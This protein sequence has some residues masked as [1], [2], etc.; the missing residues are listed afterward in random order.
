MKKLISLCSLVIAAIPLLFGQAFSLDQV[1]S[2][3]FTYGMDAAR[4]QDRFVWAMNESGVRNLFVAEG[5]DFTPRQLT[6]Y[7]G[8]EGQEF[9]SIQ[10][11]DNGEWIMYIRGGDFGSNWD[12]EKPVNPN[13]LT[14]VPSVEIWSIPFDGGDPISHG[15]GLQ[16]Q[17]APDGS[18]IAFTKSDQIW[19]TPTNG[20]TKPQKLFQARGSNGGISWGPDSRA[21]AFTSYRGDHSFIG[22]YRDSLQPIE[23]VTPSFHRDANVV[24]SPDGDQLAFIRRPGVGGA[25]DSILGARHYPWKI[26]AYDVVKKSAKSIWKAPKTIAGSPPTTQGRYNLRWGKDAITFLSYHDKWPHLYAISAKGGEAQLLTDGNYMAEY[27]S[28]SPDGRSLLFA[29]NTGPDELDIDRRHVVQVSVDG[30]QENV[31]TPGA[32]NEWTPYLLSSGKYIACISAG[33]Q[34]PPLPT[35]ID[36]ETKEMTLLGEDRIPTNFPA[37]DLVIPTQVVFKAPDGQS[38]HG[39]LFKKEGATTPAPAVVYIHGGPPRQMLLGWHYSSYYSNA[40]ALNQY[41]ANQGFVVLSVNYRLGIGYGYDFHR[42][43]DG[44]TRGASEYQ[45]IKAAGEWLA[46]QPEV[47][48]SRVSVYGGSYGGYL[49]AMALGRDS[50]LFAAGVDIHGVHDRINGRV[51]RYK[52]ADAYELAPDVEEAIKIAWQSSPVAD[53]AGWTSP[54]LIIHGDDDRN[55]AFSQSVDLVQRLE[56]KGVEYE[57]L[58]IVDD[59]H[60][61]MTYRN[62]KKVNEATADFLIRKLKPE[63][64]SQGK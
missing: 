14:E 34:R 54:V 41:L 58:V 44:G 3:P 8:D 43:V 10:I 9:S 50:E 13:F 61:F 25:P 26:M 39:T 55:V 2:Y 60:H 28:M 49:T 4:S 46:A 37:D 59:T 42:P 7:K 62:Q 48:A 30:V 57:T 17:L 35:V 24:W 5:P 15:E 18:Q 11:S 52:S 33:A 21:L 20:Q 64:L 56:A 16:P 51:E 19:L 27:I 1:M 63:G 22:I 29:G 32:G 53:V 6:Q 36:V 45:D 23:W 12:D 40:Y 31:W 38:I 47:D